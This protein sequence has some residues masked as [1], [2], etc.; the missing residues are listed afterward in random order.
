MEYVF[1][2][3]DKSVKQELDSSME[4]IETIFPGEFVGHYSFR[5]R[6]EV[7][8]LQATDLFAW[9]CFQAGCKARLGKIPHPIAH[10][11]ALAYHAAK[12]REWWLVQ[13]LN[14]EGIQKWIEENKGSDRTRQIIAF[15]E[16]WREQRKRS[17]T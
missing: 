14:R 5:N 4:Y 8:A 13:S 17:I 16:K 2:T 11:S 10:E 15:K 12:N 3:A 7:P 9:T 6:K 1:D